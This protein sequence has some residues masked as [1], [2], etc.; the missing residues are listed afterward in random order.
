LKSNLPEPLPADLSAPLEQA[1]DRLGRF[2]RQILWYQDVSSTNDIAASLAEGGAAEGCVVV[3]NVQSAGR[4]RQGRAWVSPPGA[5]LYVST[6]LRPTADV[7]PLVTIAAGVAVAEG[8]EAATGLRPDLKWPND[9]YIGPRKVAGVLA[10]AIVAQYVILGFGINVL[11]ASLPPDVSTLATSLEGELGRAVD[12]GLLLSECL[13]AFRR[14]YTDLQEGRGAAVI[15][16]WRIRAAALLRRR[17]QSTA[18]GTAIDGI[19]EDIDGSGAL[20]VRTTAGIAR[21]T[22]GE[23]RWL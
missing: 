10:E 1:A 12:R 14:Q 18:T 11:P 20:M 9:V 16:A 2:G 15:Q 13:S 8:I 7:M 6:I 23:V 3:A 22:S 17:V 4:G 5:G 21:I 19:A